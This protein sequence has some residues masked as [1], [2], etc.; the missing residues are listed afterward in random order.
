[1]NNL[2]KE[3]CK[4]YNEGMNQPEFEIEVYFVEDT[5]SDIF[6]LSVFGNDNTEPFR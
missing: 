2:V 5:I 6:E 4:E 3:N 1:M